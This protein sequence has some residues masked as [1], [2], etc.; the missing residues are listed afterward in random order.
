MSVSSNVAS[1]RHWLNIENVEAIIIPSTDPHNSEYTPEHWKAREWA[2]GFNG[3]AGTA[4]ITKNSAALWTD[5]RYFIQAAHQLADTP[6]TLM[7]EGVE[8]TPTI[9]EWLESELHA[10]DTVA[11][12]GEMVSIAQFEEW[13][14]TEKLNLQSVEDP[15]DYLWNDRPATECQ[16]MRIHFEHLA[17][18]SVASKLSRIREACG[19]TEGTYL[20]MNDLSEIAWTLNLRGADVAYNPVFLSYLLIY[21]KG[22]IL[23]VDKRKLTPEVSEYLKETGVKV[24]DYNG[25]RT[26]IADH[27]DRD[28]YYMLPQTISY[29]VVHYAERLGVDYDII[30]CPVEAIRMIK[31]PAEQEG[32]RR[33]MVNDGVAMVKFLRWLEDNVPSGKIT[34]LDAEAKLNALRQEHPEFRGFSF[35]PIMGYAANGAI[36]HREASP[37]DNS[38]LLPKGLLLCDSG[39]HYRSGTTDI[40]RTIA[41]GDTTQEERKAYTL[42][43][44]GHIALAKCCFPEGTTGIQ[45]DLAARYAMWQHG[46]DFGHGTGHGVGSRLCVHE[47]PH[48]IRKNVRPSTLIPFK[49]GMTITNEPGIYVEDKFGI[50]IENLLLT[51]EKEQN[52]FGKFLAF[53]TLTLCP[54]DVRPIDFSL[55]TAE[56][57]AWLN[58]Y[59]DSVRT[60]LM[61]LLNDVADQ[62]WL[63]KATEKI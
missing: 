5:S 40:T 15:F 33:A 6:F 13:T 17:G 62:K 41:L 29:D 28:Q 61:P 23:F 4:V 46:Y 20:L 25:L 36:V 63:E 38:T 49:A 34:E 2:T 19:M 48:Q 58:N 11:F 3:S 8:G 22:A 10:G 16:P 44:K 50:R 59:H 35:A 45:L 39:A 47:G 30:E 9:L 31:N 42:V 52:A 53:E 7:K 56:E 26:F 43:L 57:K 51:I 60:A 21:A 55:L 37:E 1:I 54:I 18:E 27:N 24:R 14:A 32:F 12:V